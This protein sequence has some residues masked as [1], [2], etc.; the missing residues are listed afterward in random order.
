MNFNPT[1]KQ[2]PD[3]DEVHTLESKPEEPGTTGEQEGVQAS[4]PSSETKPKEG[5]AIAMEP[6]AEGFLFIFFL[7]LKKSYQSIQ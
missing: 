2:K 1:K 5:E 4:P 3:L 6:P 7:H